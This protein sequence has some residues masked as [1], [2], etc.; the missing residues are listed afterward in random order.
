M[1][2]EWFGGGGG[3]GVSTANNQGPRRSKVF[4]REI[5]GGGR[6]R[7]RIRCGGSNHCQLGFSDSVKMK[8]DTERIED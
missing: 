2:V 3:G 8:T 7:G 4:S 6:V 1:I 5:S